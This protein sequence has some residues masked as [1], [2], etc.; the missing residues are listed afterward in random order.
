MVTTTEGNVIDYGFILRDIERLGE[1]YNIKEIAFDRWG[2]GQIS[3]QLEGLGFE[4]VGFGQGFKSMKN[5]MTDLLRLVM[6][7]RLAHGGNPVLRWMADN[8]V[9]DQ[10]PA[11]NVKP[12]KKKSRDKIDGIVAGLMGLDRAI[13]HLKPGKSVYEGRGIKTI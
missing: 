12:N 6:S 5:P 2:A 11:G 13:R 8:M 9:V 10:D 1:I 3:Q 7:K 4:M